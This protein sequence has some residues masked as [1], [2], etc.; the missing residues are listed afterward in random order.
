MTA[1]NLC[2]QRVRR[3]LAVALWLALA[4]GLLGLPLPAA[5]AETAPD[6]DLLAPGRLR[7]DPETGVGEALIE[8]RN[9]AAEPRDL[10]LTAGRPVDALSGRPLAADVMFIPAGDA[11]S[12][13]RLLTAAGVPPGDVVAATVR[14]SGPEVAAVTRIPLRVAL[15]P[16]AGAPPATAPLGELSA[17][18]E[19]L[20]F[21]LHLFPETPGTATLA[22]RR[23]ARTL[24]LIENDDPLAYRVRWSVVS[25]QGTATGEAEVPANG[26]VPIFVEPAAGWFPSRPSALFGSREIDAQLVLT[27]AHDPEALAATVTSVPVALEVDPWR[28]WL[29]PLVA[30]AILLVVLVLGALTSFFIKSAI[31][32]GLRRARLESRLDRFAG[33]IRSLSLSMESQVRVSLRVERLLLLR[34]LHSTSVLYPVFGDVADSV[35]ANLTLLE[36]RLELLARVDHIRLELRRMAKHELPPTRMDELRTLLRGVA[37]QL[38]AQEPAR[39]ELEAATRQVEAAEALFGRLREPEPGWE[40]ALGARA[41]EVAKRLEKSANWKQVATLGEA[42]LESLAEH[43]DFVHADADLRRLELLDEYL[44][45]MDRD[46]ALEAQL[47]APR[48][49][50]GHPRLDYLLTR[51]RQ[52]GWEA[53]RLSQSMVQQVRERI[54]WSQIEAALRAKRLDIVVEEGAVYTDSLIHLALRFWAT[55]LNQASI[56][57]A[58]GCTW[59]FGHLDLEEPGWRVCHYFPSQVSQRDAP[60]TDCDCAVERKEKGSFLVWVE[61]VRDDGEPVLTAAGDGEEARKVCITKEIKVLEGRAGSAGQEPERRGARAWL[62]RLFHVRTSRMRI[63]LAR[64]AVA[65]LAAALGLLAVARSQIADMDTWTALVAVFVLGFGAD[66]LKNLV[67]GEP[68]GGGEAKK[69]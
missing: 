12:P 42:L 1:P 6:W 13:T 23:G 29:R 36:Q 19:P 43:S 45:M 41:K 10:A 25:A 62:A 54:Y 33:R 64:L 34:S 60:P 53:L 61:F 38:S 16:A 63:E 56:L 66:V 9:R 52:T 44:R 15:P 68:A 27:A 59:H 21:H 49:E 50:G 67:A 58:L 57:G 4:G 37:E 40:S 5:G 65:I 30:T 55:S 2:A 24:L 3:A 35:E 26:R 47:L 8:V 48:E 17:V 14:V 51:L 39:G 46:P 32:N 22:V 11:A 31:P 28:P 18:P 69:L 7:I 20:P